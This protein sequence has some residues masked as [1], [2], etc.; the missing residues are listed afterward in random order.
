MDSRDKLRVDTGFYIGV[1]LSVLLN[2]YIGGSRGIGLT[3]RCTAPIVPI[4]IQDVRPPP[5]S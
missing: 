5:V 2:S 4:P 3:W 1:A